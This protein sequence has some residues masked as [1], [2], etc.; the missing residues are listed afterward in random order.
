[1]PGDLFSDG[2]HRYTSSCASERGPVTC[3][4]S[5]CA[6]CCCLCCVAWMY[7]LSTCWWRAR[8]RPWCH[9]TCAIKVRMVWRL[10]GSCCRWSLPAKSSQLSACCH[11]SR[12]QSRSCTARLSQKTTWCQRARSRSWMAQVECWSACV[13][14]YRPPKAVLVAISA[15]GVST[16][17]PKAAQACLTTGFLHP[18]PQE[19]GLPFERFS[20]LGPR[21]KRRYEFQPAQGNRF[22]LHILV[23]ADAQAAGGMCKA[24]PGLHLGDTV[25]VCVGTLVIGQADESTLLPHADHGRNGL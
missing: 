18:L 6:R 10:S 23:S 16:S 13:S 5:C 8:R 11:W 3:W 25:L 19:R 24:V 7:A 22:I 1:M 20:R 9:S 17:W 21:D 2:G 4:L 15:E 12:A 14:Q